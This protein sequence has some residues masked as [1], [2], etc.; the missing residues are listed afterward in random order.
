MPQLHFYVPNDLADKIRQEA[1]AKHMTVSRYLAEIVKREMK[2]G[3]PE[4]YFEEVVGGWV[5]EPL[6]RPT[7]GE[8][9]QREELVLP[10]S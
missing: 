8:I 10:Q 9:E 7:Q 5:G 3:W 2:Q 4:S 1:Q 6:H